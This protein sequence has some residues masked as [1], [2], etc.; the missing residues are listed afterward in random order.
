MNV[1]S[2]KFSELDDRNLEGG[3]RTSGDGR[4]DHVSYLDVILEVWTKLD[5]LSG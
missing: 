1:D 5:D 2:N 4:A 3:G